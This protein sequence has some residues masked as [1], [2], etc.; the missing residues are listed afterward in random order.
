MDGVVACRIHFRFENA[1]V[2]EFALFIYSIFLSFLVTT[3]KD[4]QRTVP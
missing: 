1:M 4:D 2:K 3:S